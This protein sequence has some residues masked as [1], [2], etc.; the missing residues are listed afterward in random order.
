MTRGWRPGAASRLVSV[1][2]AG[3]RLGLGRTRLSALLDHGDLVS[4]KIGS[5]RLVLASSLEAFIADRRARA[6]R[7]GR[8][9]VPPEEAE[10][11]LP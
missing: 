3:T 1:R 9:R 4:I 8:V 10:R 7:D 2:D 5:R 6:A 11:H